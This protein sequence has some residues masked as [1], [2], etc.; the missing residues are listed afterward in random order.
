MKA[1]PMRHPHIRKQV[2]VAQSQTGTAIMIY[3]YHADSPLL[4]ELREQE[5]HSLP[6]PVLITIDGEP[7]ERQSQGV[8]YLTLTDLIVTSDD[9]AAP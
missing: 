1:C 3:A 9:P 5:Y 7:V 4:D 8:Y 6:D 2:F